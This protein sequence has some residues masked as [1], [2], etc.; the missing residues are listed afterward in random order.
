MSTPLLTTKLYV[1]PPRPNLVPRARLVQR[2]K[3]GLHLGKKLTLVSAPAGFGKTTLL[4]AWLTECQCPVA[5]VSLDASDNQPVR[6]FSYLIAALQ[7]IA[8]GLGEAAQALLRLPQLPPLESVL[9]VLIN[10]LCTRSDGI[11]ALGRPTLLVLDDYHAIDVAAI[12][13]A[14]TFLLDNLPPPSRLGANR[15]GLHVVIATRADP[16]LPLSRWRSRGQLAELRADDL[17]FTVDEATALFNKVMRLNLSTEQIA[18]LEART[19]GWIAGLQ[20]ATLS[21]RDRPTE[22]V[23]HFIQ[24]FSG[25]HH[26]ILDYLME[27]VLEGQPASVQT[28]LLRTSILDRLTG[29]LCDEVTGQT[30][31]RA[32]LARLDRA[33]LFL[34]PLDEERRWYRY[35]QLFADLLR[36]QLLA[37]EPNVVPELHRRASRWHEQHGNDGEAVHHALEGRDWSRAAS[38]M[39][40]ASPATWRS[41][42]ISKL[43]TWVEVLPKSAPLMHPRLGIYYAWAAVLTGQYDESQRVLAGIEPLI[44]EE[45]ALQVDWLAVQVFLARARGQQVLAIE[46]A[47]RAL[48][49]P[50]TGSVASRGI[51][52]LS[53][54]VACWD[55][56][57]VKET[58]AAAEK[59]I[60]LAE[61]AG[62]WH[63]RAI[64]LAFL[65]LAQAA[66]GNLHLAFEIY[67]RAVTEQPDVPIWAG[68]G[69]AQV[70]LAAL[71][72]EWDDLDKATE[73][74]RAGLD[75]SQFTGHSEIQMNCYRQLA[76]IS[77]AQGDAHGVR[78][79]LNEAETVI[80]THRL[81]RLWGPEHVQL[82]LAQGDLTS[83]E[84][85]MGKVQG[86]YG[87]AIHYPA[88]PLEPA[89]LALAQGDNTRAATILAQLYQT[90]TRDGIRYAQ[91]EIR[92]LQ[93]LAARD[94]EHALAYL[95][96]ALKMAQ[97]EGY[98]R[99]FLDQGKTV[100]PLLR[101]AVQRGIAQD[102]AARLLVAMARSPGAAP[103]GAQPFIEPLSE[104]E[105]EVL[106]LVAAGLS[107]GEIAE[108]LVIAIG[109]VKAHTSSIYR[110]LDVKG[111][112]QAVARAREME[113]L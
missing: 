34:V 47:Q 4:S 92:I 33:N 66:L 99:I 60:R 113:L 41:G 90:A 80:H 70:C 12:H 107:N 63:S 82:A 91:I 36:H 10:E 9:T 30:G 75:L 104:R 27:E 7:K 69:F 67:Q 55:L 50:E 59:A 98:V 13:G 44:H 11:E 89:K 38:L 58:V 17:R 112:T 74:A 48:E 49:L 93:A 51:L 109:T 96:Q 73:Y 65:G 43:L 110:K 71:Y 28:F 5:W 1:P 61:Q 52:M 29:S 88:L 85:W 103:S 32:T 101:T 78:Q 37:S 6:F 31:G 57:R 23:S 111:R 21:L 72:Y 76:F 22:K 39:D 105:M 108:R 62:D 46:L 54:T 106:Q 83:A 3:E 8:P 64:L 77:Q 40:A 19:E 25:S 56:G 16:A 87:A 20:M 97:P 79:V 26:Y 84:Y 68:A 45:P 53:L 100:I 81:P 15:P 86:D 18:A 14:V 24:T 35:H 102:Y 42:E 2:L 94:E 95:D